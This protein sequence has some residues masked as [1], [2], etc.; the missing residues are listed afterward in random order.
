MKAELVGVFN[1]LLL[2]LLP[3][4]LWRCW[5]GG[6]NGIRPVKSWVVGYWHSCLSG[7]RCRPAYGPADA[8][9]TLSLSSVKSRLVLLFWYRLTWVVPDKGPLNLCVCCRF[10]DEE[11]TEEKEGRQRQGSWVSSECELLVIWGAEWQMWW[12]L[13]HNNY[14]YQFSEKKSIV[15]VNWLKVLFC[16]V[17]L[18]K[19]L[20]LQTQKWYAMLIRF[21]FDYLKVF[22]TWQTVLQFLAPL[23]L[24]L[25]NRFISHVTKGSLII[26][27]VG[28]L[29][30]SCYVMCFL[31]KYSCHCMVHYNIYFMVLLSVS[32]WNCNFSLRAWHIYCNT[33]DAHWASISWW[34]W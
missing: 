5:L 29:Y 33:N 27:W 12:K 23:K 2:L 18:V 28:M 1:S 30:L 9:A 8:T 21:S 16:V 34:W 31:F 24:K 32:T 25:T 15:N 3:S 7:A 10:S 13:S 17:I 22:S 26:M 20:M 6:M 14:E 4:V 11:K 19:K